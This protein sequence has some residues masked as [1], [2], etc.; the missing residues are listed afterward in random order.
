[1]TTPPTIRDRIKTIQTQF[2]TRTVTPASVRDNLI[3]LTALFG[4]VLDEARLADHDF[5]LIVA[6][7]VEAGDAVSKAEVRARVTAQYGRAR[8]A[9]DTE[10]L[11][12][13][14]IRGCKN[15]LQSLDTEMSLA[16]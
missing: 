4:N 7:F 9:K 14:M 12:L 8:E 2:L 10:R 6:A 11:T 3:M 16:K 1:M 5:N 15:Y 13:E